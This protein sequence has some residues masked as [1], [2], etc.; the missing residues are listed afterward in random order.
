L[1]T[2]ITACVASSAVDLDDAIDERSACAIRAGA[3]QGAQPDGR[4]PTHDEDSRSDSQPVPAE[5]RPG[6]RV[7]VV[8]DNVDA[9]DMLA[10]LLDLLAA[11]VRVA[12]DGK[13]ALELFGSFAPEAMV[14]DLGMPVIDGFEVAR[15]VRALPGGERIALVALSGWGQ[16]KDRERTAQAGFDVHLLKP[17]DV[18]RVVSVLRGLDGMRRGAASAGAHRGV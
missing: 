2:S 15:R 10:S 4:S 13:S 11:D 14:L 5:L 17:V 16:D 12:Y 9:A 18:E 8:D 7:L 6:Y 3:G 1:E